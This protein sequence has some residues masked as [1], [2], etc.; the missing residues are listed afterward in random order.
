MR[1]ILYIFTNRVYFDVNFK[2]MLY[3]ISCFFILLIC[4]CTPEDNFPNIKVSE[5]IPITM[6]QCNNVYNNLWGYEYLHDTGLGGI[7]IVQG[8]DGF[9]AYDRS[10]AFEKNSECIISG[11]FTN[12]VVLTCGNCCNSKF[13]IIDGSVF[14]G[15]ANQA[16]KKYNTYFDGTMLFITN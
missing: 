13:N 6:P 4:S 12:D 10:C 14:E 11:G 8:M 5:T 3:K 2:N 7:I 15:E 9:L 16:L 1:F